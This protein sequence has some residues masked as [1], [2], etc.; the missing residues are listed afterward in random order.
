MSPSFCVSLCL[1]GDHQ[2]AQWQASTFYLSVCVSLG[3]VGGGLREW[4]HYPRSPGF[5]PGSL[6]APLSVTVGSGGAGPLPTH[7][8][9]GGGGSLRQAPSDAGGSGGGLYCGLHCLCLWGEEEVALGLFLPAPS[10]S[11]GHRVTP[12]SPSAHCSCSH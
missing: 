9:G 2:A 8:P 4:T 7:S 11:P 3:V 1:Y 6:P 10:S 12:P 5:G